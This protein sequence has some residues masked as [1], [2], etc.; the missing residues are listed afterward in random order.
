MALLDN[1]TYQVRPSATKTQVQSNYISLF[2]YSSQYLPDV[3][4]DI[5]KKYGNQS[6][7]GMLYMLGNESAMASDKT[8]W[9]EEGRLHTIYKKSVSRSGYV[10]T[11]P[12]HVFRLNET[13]YISD[14]AVKRQG[15]ITAVDKDTFTV[16]PYKNIAFTGLSTTN[17]T[18]WSYGS[19]FKKGTF[20]MQGSLD[21]D[22]E[23][24]SNSPIILKD[25]FS[26][27]GS[28][29]A[30]IG[31]V[32]TKDGWL[33]YMLSEEDTR[34]RW[35]DKLEL[36]MI[37][38]ETAELGSN[39]NQ[40]GYKG[41]EGL[42]EAVRTRGNRFQGIADTIADWDDILKRFDA[43]GKIQDYMFYCDRDQSLAID[44]MLGEL[45][46]GYDGGVS[47]G[48]FNNSKDMAV[49][50]GFR[51]FVR[52]TYSFHKT[53]W[54]LLN[55]PTLMGGVDAAAGKIRGLLIPIGT[56]EVYEGEYNGGN[57]GRKMSTPF[58]EMKYRAAGA[59]NRKYKTWVT[60]S[61]GGNPTDDQDAMH[62]HHLSERLL[63]T[64]GAN[65]FMVFEG[66]E[67]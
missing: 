65:N 42:I 57:D 61:V 24:F 10:F 22:L 36:A 34:R 51:S 27:S 28:D 31:W 53:D 55:D 12:D 19:E 35:E 1:P 44:N 9:T 8:I 16:A 3:H 58:L 7:S 49:N 18:V 2:D 64:V 33:W 52:G 38:A 15:I 63:K 46:A 66:T 17:L 54:K 39:A 67:A 40:A 14:N 5:A 62:V 13:V 4:A 23:I 47:Y 20:G 25:K 11:Q 30:Q 41:T 26:V 59:E 43:Q 48:I 29:A 37:L 21:T 60:G 45:N 32:K 50:L 6:I 56:K